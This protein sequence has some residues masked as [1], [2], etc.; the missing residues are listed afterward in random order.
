M[1]TAIR[2]YEDVVSFG[3]SVAPWLLRAEAEHTVIL[4]LLARLTGDEA[5]A[6]TPYMAAVEVDGA[7]AG[8]AMRTPPHKLIV[9]RMPAAS[10]AVL[11][12]DVVRGA[13]A[14]LPAVF[15]PTTEAR[16]FARVWCER[17][18]GSPHVGMHQRLYVLRRLRP[19]ARP[20]RGSLREATASDVPLVQQW[21]DA[22][23]AEA[24]MTLDARRHSGPRVA[25]GDIAL[26]CTDR[27][28]VSMAGISGRSRHG[29]RIGYVY[30]PPELRGRGYATAAVTGVTRRELDLGATFCCLFTDLANSTSNSIYQQIGYEREC[31]FVDMHLR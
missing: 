24:G 3:R 19:S 13:G 1:V 16:E 4:G 27:G 17:T 2:R 31:D 30:T 7:V 21:I 6:A 15:G 28:A 29:V 22:M 26:W 18:G 8:C 9:T 25:A 12:S 5:G 23:A 14:E 11:A 20:A 10:V